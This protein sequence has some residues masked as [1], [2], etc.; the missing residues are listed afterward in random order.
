[1][2]HA[3][4]CDRR[5]R[6][7][8][9]SNCSNPMRP[10][11][12]L[13]PRARPYRWAFAASALVGM[14]LERSVIRWLYGRPL[15]NPAR[16]LGHQPVSDQSV[17]QIFARRTSKWANPRG[18]RETGTQQHGAAVQPHCHHRLLHVG[19]VDDVAD[20]VAHP[21]GLFV[22]GVTQNRTMAACVGVPTGRVD[23][24]AFALGSGVAALPA[25]R[26]RRSAMS[27]PNSG[28]ATSSIPS[29]W[30]C[31]AGSA[32]LPA[33]ST[34]RSVWACCRVSGAAHRR[35]AHQDPG[36][37]ADHRLHPETPAGALCAEGARR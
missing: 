17:R 32:S 14:A 23:L 16:N 2:A 10:H 24:L 28:R 18:C 9:P 4:C 31:S 29:W 7:S 37:G 36:P 11:D 5:L 21:L 12:R 27:V 19:A 34:L 33:P 30:W 8:S 1:M 25:V 3:R 13:D 15:E 20:A 22:R 35:G 6:D 26:C